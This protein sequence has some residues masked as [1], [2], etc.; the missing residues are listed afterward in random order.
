MVDN[1]WADGKKTDR[2]K[3]RKTDRETDRQKDSH[4]DKK[5][6]KQTE[7]YKYKNMSGPMEPTIKKAVG[8]LARHTKIR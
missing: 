5:T 4:T 8:G 2:K 3:D 1:E 6:D 7:V